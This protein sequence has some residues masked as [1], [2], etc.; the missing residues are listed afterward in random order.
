MWAAR[1]IGLLKDIPIPQTEKDILRERISRV[2]VTLS[3]LEPRFFYFAFTTE[4]KTLK[5]ICGNLAD[6]GKDLGV[7]LHG[8]M[9]LDK[10]YFKHTPTDDPSTAYQ[11]SYILEP[12][13]AFIVF[14]HDI[15]DSLQT[16]DPIPPGA[17]IPIDRYN[18]LGATYQTYTQPQAI[19]G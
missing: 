4:W 6:A 18:L 13:Q 19:S 10:G 7:H 17:T 8:M 9:I 5:S 12:K 2:D 11:I 16:F 15:I 1:Q 14:I 3:D